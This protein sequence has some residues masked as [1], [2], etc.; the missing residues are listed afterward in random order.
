MNIFTQKEPNLLAIFCELRSDMK[1]NRYLKNSTKIGEFLSE[2]R[3]TLIETIYKDSKVG[4]KKGSSSVVFEVWE[5][6]TEDRSKI[7]NLKGW[8]FKS[9][10]F[11]R[12]HKEIITTPYGRAVVYMDNMTKMNAGIII[13]DYDYADYATYQNY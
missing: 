11:N 2:P 13:D 9:Y 7:E 6:A 8:H 12:N 3:Y 4:L 1:N 10:E 5:V